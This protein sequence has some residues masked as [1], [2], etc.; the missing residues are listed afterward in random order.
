MKYAAFAGTFLLCFTIQLAL[1]EIVCLL[2]DSERDNSFVYLAIIVSLLYSL[3]VFI[4]N[5]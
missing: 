4:K 2:R 5:E 1:Y 3:K